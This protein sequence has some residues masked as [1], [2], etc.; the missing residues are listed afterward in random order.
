MIPFDGA[1]WPRLGARLWKATPV[2]LALPLALVSAMPPGPAGLGPVMPFL[3]APAVFHWALYRPDLMPRGA[4]FALGLVHD[5]LTGAPFGLGALVLLL[6]HA[7]AVAWRR[8]L[9]GRTVAVVWGGF[10]LCAVFAAG[11]SWLAASLYHLAPVPPAPVAAHW[12]LTAA[13]YPFLA[14]PFAALQRELPPAA[15]ARAR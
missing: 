8:F 9:A 6:L 5:A 14:W 13:C 15:P 3:A 11:F 7:A 1:F 2:A 10:G 12:A 4:V